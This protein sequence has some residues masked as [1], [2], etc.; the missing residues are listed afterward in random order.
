[1]EPKTKRARTSDNA[2]EMEAAV[3]QTND[4]LEMKL[5]NLQDAK[6]AAVAAEDYMKAA[7]I[8]AEIDALIAS[9]N[10]DTSSPASASSS[11]LP[12]QRNA[13]PS[14]VTHDG[15]DSSSSVYAS[16]S[17]AL[18]TQAASSLLASHPAMG[19]NATHSR[20]STPPAAPPKPSSASLVDPSVALAKIE[21]ALTHAK[22]GPKGVA[23]LLQLADAQLFSGNADPE[24]SSGRSHVATLLLACL[25]NAF[26]DPASNTV[27]DVTKIGAS[28]VSSSS[29]SSGSHAASVE[30]LPAPLKEAYIG[31]FAKIMRNIG[32]FA[33]NDALVEE[34]AGEASLPRDALLSKHLTRS[35]AERSSSGTSVGRAYGLATMVLGIGVRCELM[36]DD[37]YRFAAAMKTLRVYLEALPTS[38]LPPPPLPLPGVA[39]T[40]EAAEAQLP[41]H[42]ERARRLAILSCLETAWATGTRAGAWAKPEIE[43]TF[44]MAAERRLRFPAEA[45]GAATSNDGGDEA[46]GG[47]LVSERERLDILTTKMRE[48]QRQVIVNRAVRLQNSIAH[49]MRN[50]GHTGLR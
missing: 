46:S 27:I 9:S 21:K 42:E 25:R 5:T 28:A 19:A 8:K 15:Q 44:T 6:M 17:P 24:K 12:P 20:A 4:T 34:S 48:K 11:S 22:K 16:S 38:P 36:T 49:P 1:M 30:T 33:D 39:A 10:T 29:S 31:L 26:F 47:G 35:P 41:H 43:T 18:V 37:T 2:P 40:V 45:K 32:R 13:L 7:A 50:I 3:S 23:L 14:I